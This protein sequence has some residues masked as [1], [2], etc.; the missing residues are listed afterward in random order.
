M[1]RVSD[2]VVIITGAGSGFGEAC[3]ELF[4]AEVPWSLWED[5][6]KPSISA[7]EGKSFR[8]SGFHN[9]SGFGDYDWPRRG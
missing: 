7:G 1:G 9:P 4:V 5:G 6:K 3:M 8:W 2:K